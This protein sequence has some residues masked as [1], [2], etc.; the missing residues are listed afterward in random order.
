[1]TEELLE[2]AEASART[3]FF[4]ASG[5]IVATIILAISAILIGRLLGPELYGQYTLILSA[6]QLLFLFTDFGIN[7]GIIKFAASL[8]AEGKQDHVTRLIHNV[9]LFKIFLGTAFF[10]INFAFADFF[11]LLINRPELAPYVRIA[12]FSIIF[13]VI[14]STVSASYVG[15]DKTEYDP[16][17]TNTQAIIKTIFSVALVL[18]GFSVAGAII[19]NVLGYVVAGILGLGIVFFKLL[20]PSSKTTGESMRQNLKMLLTYGTPLYVSTLVSSFAPLYQ[21]IVLAFVTTDVEI[22]NFRAATNFL[23]LL[24]IL[25]TSIA[26]ALFPAFSKLGSLNIEKIREFFKI[27]NKYTSLI[28]VPITIFTIILSKEIVQIIY[29]STY[30]TAYLFLALSCLIYFL[31]AI[32]YISLTSLFNGLGETLTT[33]KIALVAF[34]IFIILAPIFSQLYN[35]PGLIIASLISNSVATAYGSYIART[36]FKIRFDTA[37]ITKIYLISALSGIPLILTSNFLSL[38]NLITFVLGAFLYLFIYATLVP[39]TKVI[40]NPEIQTL[41]NIT[42]KSKSLGLVAKPL[43]RYWENILEAKAAVQHDTQ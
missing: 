29:G 2:A 34:L 6:P 11:A 30:E 40:S 25:P 12:S 24:G 33:L 17:T 9:M 3:S 37:P 4:L 28:I 16:L 36:R 1:M 8:R 19:G 27:A 39:L 32:G 7:Q 26:I 10:A 41:K 38:S 18:L 35:V 21:N 42:Q 31:V 5:T 14:F 43:L 23:A 22:G 15:L 13:Q 20:K